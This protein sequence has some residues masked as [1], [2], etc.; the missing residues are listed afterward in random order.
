MLFRSR[1]D[2]LGDAKAY[3]SALTISEQR[4]SDLLREIAAQKE[5]LQ[6]LTVRLDATLARHHLVV[7]QAEEARAAAAAERETL[8]SHVRHVEDRAYGEVDRTRQELKTL[9]AQLAA[10]AREH[11]SA[12]RVQAHGRQRAETALQKAQRALAEAVKKTPAKTPV[13]GQG[14]VGKTT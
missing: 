14:R 6:S 5:Q 1:D 3:Q 13:R 4:N 2:A 9:K 8:Q 12:L 11:A 7:Q 10:Q